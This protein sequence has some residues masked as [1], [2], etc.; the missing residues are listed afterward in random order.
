MG[1]EQ[2]IRVVSYLGLARARGV[3]EH[4]AEAAGSWHPGPS[5][6]GSCRRGL[7]LFK[8]LSERREQRKR[9]QAED[10]SLT[11]YPMQ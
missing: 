2:T 1:G 4:W 10:M 6:L 8:L 7:W 3:S 11:T 9:N 5:V